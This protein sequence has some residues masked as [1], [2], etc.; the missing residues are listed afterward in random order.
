MLPKLAL[1][2]MV[3]TIENA[4]RD[5]MSAMVEK[6][7]DQA[8]ERFEKLWRDQE[9]KEI[10]GGKQVELTYENEDMGIEYESFVSG[11][12]VTEKEEGSR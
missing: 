7:T 2:K 9:R 1:V 3:K 6:V 5:C 11:N 12:P 10:Q 8:V 4:M